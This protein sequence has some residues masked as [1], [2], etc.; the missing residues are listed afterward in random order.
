M[1]YCPRA[2]GDSQ[3]SLGEQGF[4]TAFTWYSIG[5]PRFGQKSDMHSRGGTFEM[6]QHENSQTALHAN[7]QKILTD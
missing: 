6:Y 4:K 5:E 3:K 2:F 7:Y 1:Y